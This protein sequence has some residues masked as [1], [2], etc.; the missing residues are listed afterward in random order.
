VKFCPHCGGDLAAYLA[1]EGSVIVPQPS[2]NQAVTVQRKYDQTKTWQ[3]LMTRAREIGGNPPDITELA[4]SVSSGLVAK[5]KEGNASTIIHIVFD[6][7]IVPEGG[8]LYQAAMLDGQ[9]GSDENQ[10][11]G[12]GYGLTNGKVDIVD[13]VPVG[14]AYGILDYWGGESQ[15]RRWHLAEPVTINPSRN[16]EKF[17]MDDNMIAFGAKWKDGERAEEGLLE[18]LGLFENGVGGGDHVAKP[19]ALEVVVQPS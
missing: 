5:L 6:K 13:E 16:G 11:R 10:L 19:I 8:I 18:L 15:H 3:E 9:M 17:F 7:N 4:F 12:L 1:A 2:A 14:P